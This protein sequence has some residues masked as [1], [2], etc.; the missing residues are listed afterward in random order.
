MTKTLCLSIAGELGELASLLA[1]AREFMRA[2]RLK[3][4]TANSVLVVLD[5]L[6]S[7]TIRW[8]GSDVRKRRIIVSIELEGSRVRV[9]V[10]DDGPAFDPLS[11][12]PPDLSRPPTLRSEG[13][14]GVH[15]VRSLV[16]DIA[17]AR[18]DEK[19]VVSAVISS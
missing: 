6:I 17:Y 2:E 1:S 13:G 4:E 12:P 14:L 15:L 8:S 18:V 11:M 5:E 10:E 19:N 9:V 7:N 16:Q 3:P